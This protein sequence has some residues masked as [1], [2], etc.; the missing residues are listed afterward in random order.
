[1]KD[2]TEM[3]MGYEKRISEMQLNMQKLERD[4]A[5]KDEEITKLR[6]INRDVLE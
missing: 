6:N 2:D 4:N 3:I 1:M 5:F